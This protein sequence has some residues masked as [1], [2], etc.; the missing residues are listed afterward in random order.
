M[1]RI[2]FSILLTLITAT[3]AL[4]A[5][6]PMLLPGRS[7]FSSERLDSKPKT[8]SC[9][10][11]TEQKNSLI[12]SH[13]SQ[14]FLTLQLDSRFT[15][16]EKQKIV[17]AAHRWNEA[18]LKNGLKQMIQIS[19]LSDQKIES[20]ETLLNCEALIEKGFNHNQVP[21]YKIMDPDKLAESGQSDAAG[22]T[23]HC[24]QNQKRKVSAI[25]LLGEKRMEVKTHEKIEEIEIFQGLFQSTITHELGH[26]LGLNHSCST[27]LNDPN[28]IGCNR[29]PFDHLYIQSVMYPSTFLPKQYEDKTLSVFVEKTTPNSND[30][31]RLSCVLPMLP[32]SSEPGF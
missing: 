21:I 4:T 5:C 13:A 11:P 20:I 17:I 24:E 19:T 6:G 18:A 16:S 25:A 32:P 7:F 15:S 8:Y 31:L 27:D 3:L 28:Y 29:L 30:E 26:L 12:L 22:I 23:V 10:I 9:S 14:D 2:Q 1:A